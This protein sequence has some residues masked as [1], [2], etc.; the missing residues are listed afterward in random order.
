MDV[1]SQTFIRSGV[2]C[3]LASALQAGWAYLRGTTSGDQ[4]A[5]AEA[6]EQE[7]P[8]SPTPPSSPKGGGLGIIPEEES[9]GARSGGSGAKSHGEEAKRSEEVEDRAG[10][11]GRRTSQHQH[12]RRTIPLTTTT[13]A[14][15]VLTPTTPPLHK[16]DALHFLPKRRRSTVGKGGKVVEV[17][18]LGGGVVKWRYSDNL[19]DMI[20]GLPPAPDDEQEGMQEASE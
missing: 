9:T 13:A 5:W 8:P 10:A 17:I 14:M 16:K 1:A 3:G 12:Q 18:P 15:V 11:S 4:E 2:A 7:P 20:V 6:E 19:P